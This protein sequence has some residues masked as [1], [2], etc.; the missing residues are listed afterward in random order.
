[1]LLTCIETVPGLEDRQQGVKSHSIP[2][3]SD[4]Q[5]H[6]LDVPPACGNPLARSSQALTRTRQAAIVRGDTL[7]S[8][9]DCGKLTDMRHI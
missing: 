1:M 4:L 8:G 5:S 6:V 3:P 7:Q 9:G 2:C